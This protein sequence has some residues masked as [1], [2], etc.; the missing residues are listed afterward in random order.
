M[1]TDNQA[2]PAPTSSPSDASQETVRKVYAKD[3]RDKDPVHTVFRVTQKSRTTA[4]SGKV[5]LSIVLADKSG[6]IDARV[7]DK[8]E[9]L[10]SVFASGDYVLV[11]GNIISF[12]GKPQVVVESIERLDPEP[13]DPKEF[14]PPA[15]AAREE[16]PADKAPADKAADQA[17]DRQGSR[18]GPGR[19]G[20]RVLR[21]QARWRGRP[22]GRPG[23]GSDSRAARRARE[24]SPREGAAPG[25][26]G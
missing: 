23:R 3:L 17:P 1:T 24:R 20:L 8:V 11:R 15:P 13:L 22:R 26:P 2:N 12:H 19:Q 4:R 7:F 25:L 14:E 5:F 18:G 10:E 9:A 6:E 21:A 16:A